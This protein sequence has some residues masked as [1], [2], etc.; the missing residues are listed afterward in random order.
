MQKHCP[1]NGSSDISLPTNCIICRQT[2]TSEHE[3]Q[4]HAKFHLQQKAFHSPSKD[5]SQPQDLVCKECS[6]RFDSVSEL[7]MH[8]SKYHLR[9]GSFECISC[10]LSFSTEAEVRAHVEVAHAPDSGQRC[11][12]CQESFDTPL[13][14]QVHLIE[15]TFAGC[16]TFACYLCGAVFTAATGLQRHM[17]THGA[18]S[19][20]YDC[21][22]C[23]LRFFFRAELENHAFVHA[24]EEMEPK[25]RIV[26]EEDK[27]EESRRC[28][29]DVDEQNEALSLSM[30]KR[31]GEINGNEISNGASIDPS[32]AELEL[33]KL[34]LEAPE[35]QQAMS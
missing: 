17:N 15:H 25:R 18:S 6:S 4:L 13:R 23:H 11:R 1:G 12:L 28:G 8:Y 22:K 14:L 29:S 26:K 34:K 2:V 32:S 31:K 7:E 20:P 19:K 33:K 21:T 35:E 27:D 16:P 24:G 9:K 30:R 3:V 5:S 10:Q